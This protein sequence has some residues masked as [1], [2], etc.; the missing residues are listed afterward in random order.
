MVTA[1]LWL[2]AFHDLPSPQHHPTAGCCCRCAPADVLLKLE[3]EGG[4]LIVP[5]D[6]LLES[7]L[8]EANLTVADLEDGDGTYVRALL[9]TMAILNPGLDVTVS[10]WEGKEE[11]RMWGVRAGRWR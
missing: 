8:A 3:V 10:W 2:A 4:V 1:G 7:Q 11:R 5:T 9:S 6:D